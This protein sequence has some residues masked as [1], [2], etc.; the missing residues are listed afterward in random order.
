MPWTRVT[1]FDS[2]CIIANDLFPMSQK[3]R[4]DRV[5]LEGKACVEGMACLFCWDNYPVFMERDNFMLCLSV[6]I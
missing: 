4:A 6:L 1:V 2:L 5:T 3:E